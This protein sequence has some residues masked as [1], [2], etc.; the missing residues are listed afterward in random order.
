MHGVSLRK[1]ALLAGVLLL[2][3]AWLVFAGCG[4]SR[5]AATEDNGYYEHDADAVDEDGWESGGEDGPEAGDGAIHM[6]GRSVLEGWFEHLGWDYEALSPVVFDGYELYYHG[7]E[8]PPGIVDSAVEVAR[9]IGERGGGIMF[10]KLCFED[11]EGGDESSARMNLERNKEI[12]RD[13][14]DAASEEGLVIIL[15]NA[16]PM[17]RAYTD[18]WLVENHLEYNLFLE[19]LAADSGGR[20]LVFDLYSV[21][22]APGGWLRPEYAADPEDSHLNGDAYSA[23]DQAW[24]HQMGSHL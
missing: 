22:A 1:I 21:L 6:C 7:M 10:F 13:V 15:G 18:Q 19:E 11:F 12:I 4:E 8:S 17:V 24:D 3:L 20:V 2:A 23:W 9:R 14:V 5:Q 16:L